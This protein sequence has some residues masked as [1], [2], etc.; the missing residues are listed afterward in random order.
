M[1]ESERREFANRTVRD[2]RGLVVLA[3][4]GHS[5]RPDRQDPAGAVMRELKP[6]PDFIQDDECFEYL[7]KKHAVQ[8]YLYERLGRM[9]WGMDTT[10]FI[11]FYRIKD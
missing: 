8:F 6:V 4:S 5:A 9:A 2:E 10:L 7:F 11:D 3:T 1:N